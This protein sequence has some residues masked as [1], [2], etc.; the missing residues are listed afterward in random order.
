MRVRVR[1]CVCVCV[2][3]C[4]RARM[5]VHVC[6]QSQTGSCPCDW[7][8]NRKHTTKGHVLW[9]SL[10]G[11][12]TENLLSVFQKRRLC[13]FSDS[14]HDFTSL[15][16]STMWLAPAD[17]LGHFCTVSDSSGWTWEW[18]GSAEW[19]YGD[20]NHHQPCHP[21]LQ[22]WWYSLALFWTHKS[23]FTGVGSSREL[24]LSCGC[25]GSSFASRPG[26]RIVHHRNITCIC[27]ST[28][29][30]SVLL[31]LWCLLRRWYQI[32]VQVLSGIGSIAVS[33]DWPSRGDITWQQGRLQQNSN[34]NQT[35][36]KA[37]SGEPTCQVTLVFRRRSCSEGVSSSLNILLDS[38]EDSG[39]TRQPVLYYA[40]CLHWQTRSHMCSPAHTVFMWS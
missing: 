36:Q 32:Q 23:N 27:C 35:F 33:C 25:S 10:A 19:L 26:R 18:H 16:F 6:V 30:S 29:V 17:Q 24:A 20:F 34:S 8:L 12:F 14:R 40:V 11:S 38:R 21:G 1:V 37:N 9:E 2:H 7:Q 4:V 28:F 13:P 3:V 31:S 22:L 5:C 15:S 39:R